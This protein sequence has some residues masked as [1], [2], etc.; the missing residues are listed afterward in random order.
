MEVKESFLCFHREFQGT[1][2]DF[3]AG[4]AS[5]FTLGHPACLKSFLKHSE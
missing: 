1:N 3:K 5:A 2:L 4:A